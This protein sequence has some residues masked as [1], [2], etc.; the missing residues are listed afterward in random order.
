[1]FQTECLLIYNTVQKKSFPE[2][3]TFRLRHD[4]PDQTLF[5]S[6]L[7]F[8]SINC[9]TLKFVPMKAITLQSFLYFKKKI[10]TSC[11]SVHATDA[12]CSVI[13]KSKLTPRINIRSC[14][15]LVRSV[16]SSIAKE[17]HKKFSA[18]CCSCATMFSPSSSVLSTTEPAERLIL[19][20]KIGILRTQVV[21]SFH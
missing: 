13:S 7:V 19:A 6:K 11:C 8:P 10:F 4:P 18:F 21:H 17:Y 5:Q 20:N 12:N 16:D 1:M 9:N 14:E 15:V 3:K 2:M